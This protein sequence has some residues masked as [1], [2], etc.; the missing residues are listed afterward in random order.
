MKWAIILAVPFVAWAGAR[1]GEDK[2]E[3]IVQDK[4]KCL[5]EVTTGLKTMTDAKTAEAALVKMDAALERLYTCDE[6]LGDPKFIGRLQKAKLTDKYD[7]PLA[8]AGTALD[9]ELERLSKVPTV[10]KVLAEAETWKRWQTLTKEIRAASAANTAR[11]EID[12]KSLEQ[13]V[14]AYF[15]RHAVYPGSLDQ[16]AARQPDGSPALIK[17]EALEDP[18]GRPY[19]FD[20]SQRNPKTDRPRIWSEGPNPGQSGSTIANWSDD[21]KKEGKK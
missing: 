13:A 14:V 10:K 3:K 1:A 7:K 18:W 6:I 21:S 17:E 16:L 5:Q 8:E 12:V 15:V 19:R 4:I 20:P 9:K 2:L 11:A